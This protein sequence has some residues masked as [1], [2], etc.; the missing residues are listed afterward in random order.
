MY[1]MPGLL[2]HHKD[3]KAVRLYQNIAFRATFPVL[4][5]TGE[6]KYNDACIF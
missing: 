3:V 6:F 5:I 4:A 2:F 1:V